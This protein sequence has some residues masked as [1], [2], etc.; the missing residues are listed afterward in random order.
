MGYVEHGH[1]YLEEQDKVIFGGMLVIALALWGANTFT[2][3]NNSK[4]FYEHAHKVPS[5]DE[6]TGTPIRHRA[7]SE[8]YLGGFF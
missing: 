4:D 6:H 5:S 8:G 1:S 7:Y 2:A 3:Y